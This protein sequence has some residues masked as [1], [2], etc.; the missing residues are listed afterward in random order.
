MRRGGA[1]AAAEHVD[2]ALLCKQKVVASHICW[3]VIVTPHGV[4]KTRVRVDVHEALG[5][6][7]QALEEGAHLRRSQG[8]V[9]TEA[10]RP[11]MPHGHV[12]T[13][14]IFCC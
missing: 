10:E 5:N 4:G 7:G 11:A 2:Q 14:R 12:K 3:R 13:L 8:A 1:A 9:Q 6:L